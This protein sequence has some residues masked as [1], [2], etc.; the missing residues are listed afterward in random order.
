MF[1]PENCEAILRYEITQ[2]S[3]RELQRC[4]EFCKPDYTDKDIEEFLRL[5]Q[6]LEDRYCNGEPS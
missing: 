5:Y 6:I 2:I 4:Y 1:N 3:V